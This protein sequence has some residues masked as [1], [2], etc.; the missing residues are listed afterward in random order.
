MYAY[1]LRI[2]DIDYIVYGMY[3]VIV[4]RCLMKHNMCNFIA[5]HTLLSYNYVYYKALQYACAIDCGG[6]SHVMSISCPKDTPSCLVS[7]LHSVCA[8]LTGYEWPKN[9]SISTLASLSD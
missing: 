8:I 3:K 2:V 4:L 7:V 1:Q 5:F 9:C 6:M